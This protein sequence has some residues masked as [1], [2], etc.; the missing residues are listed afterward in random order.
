MDSDWLMVPI[1]PLG[2]GDFVDRRSFQ[3][4]R[5]PNGHNIS[6][7]FGGY[8]SSAFVAGGVL[9]AY[10]NPYNVIGLLAAICDRIC[11]RLSVSVNR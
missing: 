8:S 2:L 11:T 4:Q 3:P 10:L 7:V 5:A 6:V 9:E 1:L